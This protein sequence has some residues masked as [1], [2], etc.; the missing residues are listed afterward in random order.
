MILLKKIKND[1]LTARK[2]R[3]KREA[4]LLTTLYSEAAMVGKNANNRESTDA[5][6]VQMVKKF[7]KGVNDTISSV[8]LSETRQHELDKEIDLYGRYLPKQLTKD[9]LDAII[10]EQIN[11]NDYTIPKD[12]GKIMKYLSGRYAGRYDGKITSELVK[13]YT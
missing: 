1:Q 6:V 2:G 9:E 5:E 13:S 8:Q 3:M 7:I 12:M 4:E 11:A 10:E